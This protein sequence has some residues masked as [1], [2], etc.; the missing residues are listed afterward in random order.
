MNKKDKFK[1][2]DLVKL[3]G[4]LC[5][6]WSDMG[7]VIHTENLYNPRTDITTQKALVVW[8]NQGQRWVTAPCLKKVA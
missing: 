3:T 8:T 6:R 4:H 7:V 5:D 1:V 2:G